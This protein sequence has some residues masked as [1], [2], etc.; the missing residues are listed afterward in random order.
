[1]RVAL[2]CELLFV[3]K[4][5]GTLSLS[6]SFTDSKLDVSSNKQLPAVSKIKAI[7][8]DVDGTL[9]DSDPLHFLAFQEILQEVWKLS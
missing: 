9:A 7:L 1:M 4:C 2:L 8:F 5:L 6:E 3:E